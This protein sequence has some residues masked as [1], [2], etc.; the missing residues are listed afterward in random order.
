MA[1]PT[2]DASHDPAFAAILDRYFAI[3]R[4]PYDEFTR[5]FLRRCQSF[6]VKA[7][8]GVYK[9]YRRGA[10]PTVV[11]AHGIHSHLG[12]MVPI[13][14]QLL[15]LGYEVVLFDMPAHGEA[16]G[17]GTDPVQV[18]DF[19]RKVCARLGE[20]HA[21]VSHSLGGL[22][23]LSAMHQGFRA[24][25]FV[26]ISTP[27]TT[28]FLVEKF[29]QLNQ[30]DGEVEARLCAELERRYGATLWTD[31]APRHIAGALEVPGLVIHGANDDF[32]PPAH[33]Q[34]LYDA[35][36]GATLEI[37]DGAG[38]FEILGLS[39]VGR[40]VGAYLQ[41]APVAAAA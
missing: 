18:R 37:V 25:A 41:E 22:W 30:L 8:G 9:Y 39:A 6:S 16:A 19:I 17:S 35:W 15:D 27:S 24:D 4:V 36:P 29:V 2:P 5:A 38:H 34:E 7:N 13:A 20:V 32:V 12:S 28:R 26:S 21:V 10:G 3:T 40:R 14:E 23:A 11:L 31:Y 1:Q 33:A